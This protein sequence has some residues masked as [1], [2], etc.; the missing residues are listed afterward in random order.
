LLQNCETAHPEFRLWLTTESTSSFPIALLQASLKFR[1]KDQDPTIGGTIAHLYNEIGQQMYD[2]VALP[3]WRQTMYSL[4]FFHSLIVGRQKYGFAGWNMQYQFSNSDFHSTLSFAQAMFAEAELRKTKDCINF[5]ALRSVIAINYGGRIT[6]SNDSLVLKTLSEKYISNTSESGA[7][8]SKQYRQPAWASTD[9]VQARQHAIGLPA[10]DKAEAFGFYQ[11]AE[12]SH[13]T[14]A[15]QEMALYLKRVVGLEADSVQAFC[16][17]LKVGPTDY[18]PVSR[19]AFSFETASSVENVRDLCTEFLTLIPA[20]IEKGALHTRTS[21]YTKANG[22]KSNFLFAF[23]L[24]ELT[25]IEGV[26][27]ST[28]ALLD[29]I[30]RCILSS[31]YKFNAA[32][33][34]DSDSQV[35]RDISRIY[36]NIT[37]ETIQALAFPFVTNLRAWFDRLRKA[38]EQINQFI[39]RSKPRCIWLGGINSPKGLLTAFRI[40]N[41]I[42]K[43]WTLEETI[44]S[45]ELSRYD[46]ES[47]IKEKDI[48]MD[49]MY[50]SGCCLEGAT[51]N[52][53]EGRLMELSP[54]FPQSFCPVISV[55]ALLSR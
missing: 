8:F 37:P 20:T 55:C 15:F 27:G 30:L 53:K 41:A 24:H 22:A 25:L 47:Q 1:S 26:Y 31:G 48:P 21:T 34:E 23:F 12:F 52:A 9:Y 18:R 46:N 40:E 28:N 32:H 42:K 35:K 5:H 17:Q 43:G 2:S 10:Q 44:I 14:T 38:G 16:T 51:W 6:D 54:R 45:V 19:S 49:V 13:F 3:G 39:F 11:N 4:A 33:D 29:R 7:L 36:R 50:I